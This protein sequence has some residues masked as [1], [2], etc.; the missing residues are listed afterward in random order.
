M[1]PKS[2]PMQNPNSKTLTLTADKVTDQ[3]RVQAWTAA[4]THS[5]LH[6]P[7]VTAPFRRG[8]APLNRSQH[9]HARHGSLNQR[10]R[11]LQRVS[12][13]ITSGWQ[14]L[15][16]AA[17]WMAV[18]LGK[19]GQQ[20]DGGTPGQRQD[21]KKHHPNQSCNRCWTEAARERGSTLRLVLQ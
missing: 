20:Q 17:R 1:P 12:A 18:P 16:T 8:A 2:R 21:S 4:L 5:Q 14:C 10:S 7:Q 11:L 3:K 19:T 9:P 15:L 6:S 13:P